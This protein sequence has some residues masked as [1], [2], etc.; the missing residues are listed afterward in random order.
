M[1]TN[2]AG[3]SIVTK[4][5]VAPYAAKKG[6][7]YMSLGQVEHFKHLL[8]QWK[9]SLLNNVDVT[10]SHLQGDAGH[11]ADMN[12]RA[13]QEEEFSL[14]LKTRDRERKLIPK[15]DEALHALSSGEYGYCEECGIE[16]G[17]RR[18]EARPTAT[19]CIECKTLQEVKERQTVV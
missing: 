9:A 6:E 14:E 19:L 1:S 3:S 7:A 17:I 15:I 2:S 8:M 10:V 4:V 13:T 11:V 18:L 16:I 12:D 5:Q